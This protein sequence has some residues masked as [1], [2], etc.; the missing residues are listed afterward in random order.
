M[1][2]LLTLLRPV[3]AYVAQLWKTLTVGWSDFWFTSIDP[4]TLSVVRICAGFVVLYIFLSCAPERLN[5]I[6]P[7]AWIDSQAI[8]NLQQLGTESAEGTDEFVAR[9]WGQSIWNHVH[10]E[11]AASAL[12]WG[13]VT[14]AFC[15]MVGCFSRTANLLVLVG[16]LSFVHRSYVAW[17]GMDSI[18]AMILL[19]L[20]IGPSGRA[21]SVDRWIRNWRAKKSDSPL[22]ETGDDS[23]LANVSLRMIQIH[24]CVI[25]LCSGLAK[26]QGETWWD[27]TAVLRSL[28]GYELAPVDLRWLGNFSDVQLEWFSSLSVVATLVFEIGFAF[29]IWNRLLRPLLLVGAIGLHMGIATL[30]GLIG[31]GLIMITGC[32]AFVAPSSIRWVIG[33]LTE[34]KAASTEPA[35]AE[36]A[37]T[38][39]VDA[40]AELSGV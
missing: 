30:M 13:L 24:M 3:Q 25:Y 20:L 29:L 31:F 38:E 34:P 21:Y 22:P 5:L 26:L 9:W 6:G 8:G 4:A 32:L 23:W 11:A 10:S 14:A 16:H 2:R 37:P 7:N 27:G 17:F 15:F 36:T 35:L 33:V 40:S 12:Y 19:Y 39:D 1:Q 28:M 18:L